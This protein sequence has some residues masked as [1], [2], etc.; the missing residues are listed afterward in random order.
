MVLDRRYTG[1]QVHTVKLPFADRA[2]VDATKVRDY[3]LSPE[4]PVGRFKARVFG[5]AGYHQRD[6]PRLQRDFLVLATTLDVERTASDEHGQRFVGTGTL[7]GPN[8]SL[9]PV[10]TIWIIRS[11]EAEPRFVTAYPVSAS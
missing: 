11:G 9:L 1:A 10:T 4:H 5:A 2:I 8:A 3:L 6:W 7:V